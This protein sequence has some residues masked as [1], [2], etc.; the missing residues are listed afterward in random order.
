MKTL[1]EKTKEE[2]APPAQPGQSSQRKILNYFGSQE[3]E[4]NQGNTYA[5][6]E[7][8]QGNEPALPPSSPSLLS[9][10]SISSKVISNEEA[11]PG[12]PSSTSTNKENS[13]SSS[14]SSSSKK[15]PNKETCPDSPASTSSNKEK[16]AMDGNAT[17]PSEEITKEGKTTTPSNGKK[18]AELFEKSQNAK[19]NQSNPAIMDTLFFDIV[20]ENQHKIKNSSVELD[21]TVPILKS[22]EI[23]TE[24][25]NIADARFGTMTIGLKS[26]VNVLEKFKNKKNLFHYN[27]INGTKHFLKMRKLNYLRD[28][29]EKKTVYLKIFKVVNFVKKA[30]LFNLISKIW[31]DHSF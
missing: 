9:N 8:K 29:M 26:P 17:A 20:D 14:S 13:N 21:K 1:G 18:W 16:N 11:C 10:S 4:K 19:T 3:K 28:R 6:M 7:E 25:I 12:S 27:T 23:R 30:S 2:G 15:I 24:D 5:P 31:Q 22:L